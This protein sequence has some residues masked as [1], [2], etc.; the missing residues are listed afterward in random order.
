M[1]RNHPSLNH[2]PPSHSTSYRGEEY[3][4]HSPRSSEEHHSKNEESNFESQE[5]KDKENIFLGM[6]NENEVQSWLA[7]DAL[8]LN[9]HFHNLPKQ[10]EHLLPKYD[11]DLHGPPEDHLEKLILDIILICYT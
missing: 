4:P 1:L 3:K 2:I 5:S 6:A 11:L 7:Q 10:Q 8:A 9:P